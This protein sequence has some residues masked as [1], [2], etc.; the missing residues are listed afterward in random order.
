MEK[1]NAVKT[2]LEG[3]NLIE[4]SAGTG[5]T[6]TISMIYLRLIV[7]RS[8]RI[9]RIL[10]VTFT[11]PATMELRLRTRNVIADALRFCETGVADEKTVSEIMEKHSNDLSVTQRLRGAL[12]SFDEASVYTIHSFCQQVLADNAFESGSLFSSDI[13][14][15]DLIH[16]R[17]AA[18]FWRKHIY[19][20]PEH[21][22][23][24]IIEH[25][26]PASL[27]V[28][29]K[30]RPLSPRMKTVPDATPISV[31]MINK[32]A[33]KVEKLHRKLAPLWVKERRSVEEFIF[34][35]G[36]LNGNKYRRNSMVQR[37]ADLDSYL[38]GGEFLSLPDGF[39][40]FTAEKIGA[41]LNKGRSAPDIPF[42][43]AADDLFSAAEEYYSACR[44]YLV[45]FRIELFSY[46]DNVGGALKGELGRRGF[47]DL[48]KDVQIALRRERG[49][50]LAESVRNRY[51]AALIDEF[52]DTDDLQFDIFS[53]IFGKGESILFLIGD[54]KQA[55][56]RFRG[57]DIFSYIKAS[58]M[59]Q[60]RYTLANNYR[61]TPELIECVNRVFSGAELPF[62][63]ERIKF[64]PVEAGK[65][66]H[67][68]YLVK[69]GKPLSAMDI[70]LAD[71]QA[72]QGGNDDN[73]SII[74]RQ[75]ASEISEL[76]A[77]SSCS[78]TS[79]GRGVKPSDIAVLVRSH[80][81]AASV[82]E[83]LAACGIP[84]V[85][86]GHESVLATEEA[87]ELCRII[88][89]VAEPGRSGRLKS[90]AATSII[91][92]SAADIY[93]LNDDS[94]D[95]TAPL[96]ELTEKFYDY[97]ELWVTNGFMDMFTLL[98]ANENI[99]VRVLGRMRGE[100]ALANINHLA[101]ILNMVQF[102]NSFS[103]D[104]LVAWF[105]N[106]LTDPPEGDAYSIRLD[107]DSDAVEIVTMHA[108]KGLEYP[109]VY[110]PYLTHAWQPPGETVIYHD[111][112]SD[113]AP[114][115]CL[116][117][118]SVTES[119][120]E[121]KGREDLAENVRLMYVAL[122]RAKSRCRVLFM[123]K[124]DFLKSAPAHLLLNG[125][126]P[127]KLKTEEKFA[128]FA[129]SLRNL[130]AGSGGNISFSIIRGD[131]G[132]M[133]SIPLSETDL[134]EQRKFTGEIRRAWGMQSY[135]SI[136]KTMH[137]EKSD[138]F[139]GKSV[140][141]G[142]GIFAFPRGTK[143]GLCLHEIFETTDFRE[144]DK[145]TV[146]G[147]VLSLLRKYG[148]EESWCDD[149]AAMFFNVANAQLPG[150]DGLRLSDIGMEN[151]LSEM[152]FNFPLGEFSI[153]GLHNIFSSAPLYGK[154]IF[155]S[156]GRDD[157]VIH[158]MMK[159]FI[160]LVFRA[161]EKYYIADWK[162]NS[163]GTC[164][165]DYSLPRMEEE[166]LH[167]NYHLQ[168]YLYSVALHRY[169]SLRMGGDYS[170]S[171]NFGGVYYF[172]IRGMREGDNSPGIFHTIPDEVT[173]KILDR[174]FS[175]EGE[176]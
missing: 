125:P 73:D 156:P 170:Y 56:Y 71:I 155:N 122:T 172:F 102:E 27:L 33:V 90:A 83:S 59:V 80:S 74:L 94:E 68:D 112:E 132:K 159:G 79:S 6:F 126:L 109:I 99:T 171:R 11:L 153:S 14:T 103:P 13:A 78:F 114:V 139:A 38:A 130:A 32:L 16:E 7:E 142:S 61:S 51:S 30:K 17:L 91:G 149:V 113:F 76:I 57:A 66:D 131:G 28:L 95:G 62:V 65:K 55:I 134:T 45:N 163:L 53:G 169:L 110:C 128:L 70:G 47:D 89:A 136:T 40:F 10:V 165:E 160:D 35:S 20:L 123:V 60:K 87:S 81:H 96:A 158:G 22:A 154:E 67:C 50:A 58:E 86:R 36:S 174:F 77:D 148:Y 146:S 24:Y 3:T 176:Q 41:S 4:A 15:D 107:K 135:S 44:E 31:Q 23:K 52:Q 2:P 93:R 100:R 137:D 150:D 43:K 104:E 92:M 85:S 173:V 152:E 48:I 108:C 29:Y 140:Y 167:H 105:E 145:E 121:I 26:S 111:P 84:S 97:R 157:S 138:G 5:K 9:D 54:P 8:L 82:Q 115:L 127:E 118:E 98:L 46:M 101:E 49:A 116:D 34:E 106:A 162:S 166:M 144:K 75:L 25:E 39:E 133:Q 151:R 37:T 88:A 18:D 168:Y 119:V 164:S 64:T 1:F 143:A 161:G 175:V 21:P 147:T 42:F 72:V 12:K 129:E 19:S 141:A 117:K 120:K 124:R 69:N 63:F